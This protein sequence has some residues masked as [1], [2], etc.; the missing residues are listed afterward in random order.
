[1]IGEE[2]QFGISPPGPHTCTDSCRKTIPTT[3]E[4]SGR[5]RPTGGMSQHK[6]IMIYGP[7]P[8]LLRI[9]RELVRSS[10]YNFPTKRVFSER[11][12]PEIPLPIIMSNP[13]ETSPPWPHTCSDS[14]R[15]TIPTTAEPS[16]RKRPTGGVP[17]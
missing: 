13:R 10:R 1:M 7:G 15:K 3:A 17:T 11:L 8:H 16:E 9:R 5:K 4:P 12:G 14:H 2:S 6:R